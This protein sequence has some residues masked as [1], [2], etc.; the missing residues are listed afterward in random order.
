MTTQTSALT[1]KVMIKGQIVTETGLH[2]GGSKSALDIGGI[3]LNVV[4]T[5]RKVP[6]IPGSS[7]KGKLRSLLAKIEGSLDVAKDSDTIKTIFGDNAIDGH[8]RLLVRDAFL[9]ETRFKDEIYDEFGETNMEQEY[10]DVKWEN[11]IDR[12]TGTAQHPRQLERVPIGTIFNF[13]MIYD[14]YDDGQKD[15]HL[16]KIITAMRLL[17]N[18]YIGGNGSRGYGQ[19]RFEEVTFTEKTIENYEKDQP[20]TLIAN[21]TL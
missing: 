17:Q 16:T 21:L 6:F 14:A 5:A 11:T 19:I 4:K 8:T 7:L 15:A 2:I 9:N 3:D 12:K 1:G 10:S 20:G 18:D 13:E